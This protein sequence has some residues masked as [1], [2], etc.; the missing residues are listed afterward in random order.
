MLFGIT[1][2]Q[3]FHDEIQALLI[4]DVC[5][6]DTKGNSKIVCDIIKEHQLHLHTESLRQIIIS[7]NLSDEHKIY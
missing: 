3:Y 2:F 7:N 4:R 1:T 5:V 6:R